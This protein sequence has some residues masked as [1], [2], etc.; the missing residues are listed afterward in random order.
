MEVL[1][2]GDEETLIFEAGYWK[3]VVVVDGSANK[4]ERPAD[5]T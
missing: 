2:F 4:E 5:Y 3:S 1:R